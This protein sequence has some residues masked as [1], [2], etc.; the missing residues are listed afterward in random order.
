MRI[1]VDAFGGDNSPDE[2]IKG[3]VM[4]ASH[5]DCEIILVGDENIIKN[6]LEEFGYSGDKITV[7]HAS[8]VIDGEDSPVEA[9]R[10]KRDSSMVVALKLCKNKEADAVVSAGNTGAYFAGA[11]RTLGRIKGIKRPALTAF[12]PTVNKTKSVM[13]DVGA[14]ADCKPENLEQFGQMGSLYAEKILGIENPKVYLVNIGTEEHKGN[15]L[16]QKAYVMLKENQNINFCGN[17]ESR[18]LTSGIADVIVCDGF[19]GNVIIKSIEGTAS[20]LFGLIKKSFMKNF[21]TKLSAL[22][23]KPHISELKSMLDYSEY[24]GVPLLGIDGVVIKAHG[25]SDAKAFENAI[26][27]AIVFSETGLN[28]EL[29]MLYSTKKETETE[30]V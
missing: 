7:H 8:E 29:K 27:S 19:T 23:M 25:S 22:M 13:M 14:N 1:A 28:D 3:S 4:A 6:K 9:V 10:H 17:I 26:K 16:S 11:F 21:A 24:G 30:V 18:E 15:D 2:I 5:A 20:A 12:M